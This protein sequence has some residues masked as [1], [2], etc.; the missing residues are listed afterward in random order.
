MPKKKISNDD[1]KE[2]F[3]DENE[4]KNEAINLAKALKWRSI[5]NN[6]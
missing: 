5:E 6:S 3:K 2:I 1:P 4:F